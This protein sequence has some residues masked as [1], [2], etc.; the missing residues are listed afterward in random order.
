VSFPISAREEYENNP[1]EEVICQLRFP[2]ILKINT[3]S[4][5]EFQDDIRKRYPLY[6]KGGDLDI[7]LPEGIPQGFSNLISELN[8]SAMLGPLT[9]PVRH[10]F[11][12][13]EGTRSVALVQNFFA[14]SE[15]DYRRWSNLRDEIEIV[16]QN[17]AKIYEPEFYSRIG[18]RYRDKIRRSTL[19]VADLEWSLLLNADLTGFFGDLDFAKDIFRTMSRIEM[20][21]PEVPGARMTLQHGLATANGED[22]PSYIIDIDL[23]T[24]ERS[25]SE[26]AF[27]TLDS[28]NS[29]AG[30]IFR[31]AIT[32]RLKDAM[33]TR[34]LND[35]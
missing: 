4:P 5:A 35:N 7:Q 26:N 11:V 18:L 1:L 16:E 23:Y 20:Q 34:V 30:N 29:I 22:E 31:W 32:D 28:F 25:T 21:M 24:T 17:F 8:I 13:S 3:E 2:T 9:P 12:T 19:G 6:E 14:I 15:T 27:Q 10:R 33:G